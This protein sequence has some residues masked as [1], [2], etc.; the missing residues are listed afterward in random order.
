M[1]AIGSLQNYLLYCEF[2]EQIWEKVLPQFILS[3][4][5]ITTLLKNEVALM[6]SI[7]DPESCL[8]PEDIRE[9]SKIKNRL[10]LGHCPYLPDLPPSPK[11]WDAYF[12][13]FRQ[14]LQ[15]AF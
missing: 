14:I 13:I 15:C 1:N 12:N 11:T 8:L 5:K 6:I 3:N 4:P 2:G 10:N 7:L 9:A